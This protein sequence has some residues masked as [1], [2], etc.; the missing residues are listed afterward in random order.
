MS[1]CHFMSSLVLN[2]EAKDDFCAKKGHCL[3]SSAT[4]VPKTP[5]NAAPGF[6]IPQNLFMS[7]GGEEP[8]VY[9]LTEKTGNSNRLQTTK[10]ALSPQAF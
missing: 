6:Y 8:I 2:R 1:Q 10:A 4:L 7:K 5:L 9:G 3:K